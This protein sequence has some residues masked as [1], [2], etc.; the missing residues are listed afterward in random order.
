MLQSRTSLSTTLASRR[1]SG[2]DDHT[3]GSRTPIR[4]VITLSVI[5]SKT[6]LEPALAATTAV[7]IAPAANTGLTGQGE[8]RLLTCPF[9]APR[10][11]TLRGR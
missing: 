4:I 8:P 10:R 2:S 11:E 9:F 6:Q 5:R 3:A 1:R 7:P